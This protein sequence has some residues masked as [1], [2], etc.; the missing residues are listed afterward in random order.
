MEFTMRLI[1]FILLCALSSIASADYLGFDTT[2]ESFFNITSVSVASGL[3]VTHLSKGTYT[4]KDTG[5]TDDYNE[6]NDYVAIKLNSESGYELSFARFNNSYYQESYA[7]G[8]HKDVYKVNNYV[9]LGA[10][11][12]MSSGYDEYNDPLNTTIVTVPSVYFRVD[13]DRFSGKVSLLGL[14]VVAVTVEYKIWVK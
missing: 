13:V 3:Y 9:S 7:V 1:L 5:L 2:K 11:L 8:L 14:T 6:S 12:L 4:N 10:E